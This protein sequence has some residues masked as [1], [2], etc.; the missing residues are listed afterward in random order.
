MRIENRF[1]GWILGVVGTALVA[2]AI[3]N[4]STLRAQDIDERDPPGHWSAV[5]TLTNDPDGNELAVFNHPDGDGGLASPVF[6][7][8]G[9]LGAGTGLSNQGALALS[10]DSQYLYAV[11]PA[12]DTITV[13]HLG[14]RG[15]AR[16]QVIDSAGSNPIS[17]TVHDDALYVLNAGG[18]TEGGVDAIA[19]FRIKHNGALTR[20]KNSVKQLS[21]AST[22]PAQISFDASGTVLAVTER[23]TNLI[24][25]FAVNDDSLPVSQTSVPS[26]GSTPFGFA[27]TRD[28][29]LVVSE[30]FASTVSSYELDPDEGT[31]DSVSASVKTQQA[32]AC[33]IAITSDDEFAYAANAGSQSITGFKIRGNGTLVALVKSG[34]SA[35]TGASPEDLATHG[36]RVLFGLNTGDGSVS[37]YRIG[38]DGSLTALAV[39]GGL[40]LTHPT[41]LVVR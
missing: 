8:T 1:R 17:L 23:T 14:S 15:P 33:W 10:D 37:A 3:G 13:F 20:L 39:V 31:L 34:V 2:T 41:G 38:N 40:P 27:F 36:N 32:A 30:A 19:G 12:S 11:N 21:A 9:G 7:S 35:T 24:T 18:A 26:N 29:L 16:V 6:Y 28:D 4:D 22:G 5:F 25:L